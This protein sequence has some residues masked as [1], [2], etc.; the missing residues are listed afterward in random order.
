[1][2]IIRQDPTTKEWVIIAAERTRRPHEYARPIRTRSRPTDT[3]SCPF[4]PG[5]EAATPDEVFRI[6]GGSRTAWAVRVISNKYP[7]LGATGQLERRET[8][9]LFRE[10][11]GVGIHEVIIET[12]IHDQSLPLMTDPEVAD[13]L[14]AYQA[15]YRSLQND[16]RL[17]YIIVFKNHGEAAGT[18]LVHPHS[19]L[20]ATPVPPMLLR[21]KYEV[22][23]SHHDDTGRC[24]YCD[25]M[26]EERK[27]RSRVVMETD[28]FL[29]FHPFASRVAFETW[30]MPKRHQPSFGQ[31]SGEDLRELAPVLRR[32]LRTLYDRLGDPDF[33][34][35][36]HSA[37][38]EDE[39]KDYYL[40]HIQILPRLTTI[41]GFELGS[42]I[43]VS[44]M[45]PE[46]SAAVIREYAQATAEG[47][48]A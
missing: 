23:V 35:I 36:I 45:Q 5:H 33:N 13:V 42:G 19:Q 7:A 3:G 15:R 16:P 10:M 48:S 2:S 47:G 39:N 29:V 12:P 46:D 11:D 8:G 30:I 18:S 44:T 1:M 4:C 14:T 41:A 22:A 21:R 24:L 31:V 6:P 25:V 32:T 26:D 38:T 28:R 40:W 9:S 43:Y 20:V 17:K 37:P 34:Y 27:A